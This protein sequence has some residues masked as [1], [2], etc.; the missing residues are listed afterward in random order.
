[1]STNEIQILLVEDNKSDAMLTMRALQK[2]KLVNHITHLSDGAEAL[3]FVFGEGEYADR[4]I[5]E[6]PK[7]IFLDLKMP[8]VDGLEVLRILKGDER[9]K[10]IPIVMMT[11]SK[12]EK[13][14][15]E[16]HKL[17]VNSYV[18]K[19]V[20]FENFSK[21]IADLGFYWLFL[22]HTPRI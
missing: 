3:D 9:T 15:I 7:V 11:S 17:G 22:N 6:K 16:S 19:P 18:V 21:T 13:D 2:H 10:L 1:M 14:I 12:E 4:N 5:E 8:K 20:G